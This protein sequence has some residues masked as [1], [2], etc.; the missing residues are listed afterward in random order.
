[1][2]DNNWFKRVVRV[3]VASYDHIFMAVV[4]VRLFNGAI[5]N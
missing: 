5:F 3:V 1:M 4:T 2:A